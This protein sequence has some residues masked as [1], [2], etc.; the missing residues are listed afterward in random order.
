MKCRILYLIGQLRPGGQERQLVWLIGALDRGRYAPAV[1]VWNMRN[2]DSY[3]AEIRSLG[4]PIYSLGP[5]GGVPAKL[6]RLRRLVRRINPEVIHSYSSWTNPAACWGASAVCAL[7]VG[8]IRADYSYERRRLG[9]LLGAASC[10]W[11]AHQIFNS[12]AAAEQARCSRDPFKPRNIHVVRNGLRLESFPVMPLPSAVKPVILGIGSLYPV[13][14]WDRVLRAARHLKVSGI[15]YALRIAGDGPLRDWLKQQTAA[16]DVGDRVEFL[17][18]RPNVLELLA[19]ADLLV[20]GSDSEGCPN[21]VME[22]MACGRAVIAT[23][24]GDVPALVE[25]GVTGLLVDKSDTRGLADSMAMLVTDRGLCRRMGEAGRIKAEKD[26]SCER[27]AA[28]TMDV[29]RA[30]GWSDRQ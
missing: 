20:L 18:H 4:V 6:Q 30:A 11:P 15:D 23:K 12:F 2:G 1:A 28:Q 25:A 14:Q 3:A 24:V 10:Y 22:A 17:G 27:L 26:F 16:L 8:S 9:A 21:V 13:K 7:A 29:Y 19:G 5:D